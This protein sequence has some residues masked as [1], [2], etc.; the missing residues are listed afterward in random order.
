MLDAN[1]S[2][3]TVGMRRLEDHRARDV[4]HREGVLAPRTQM[5]ELNFSGSSVAIGA[6]TSAS[7]G[8]S[9]PNVR[10]DVLDRVHEEDRAED[11][12]PERHEDLEVHDPQAR[13]VRLRAVRVPVEPMEAERRECLAARPRHRPRSGPC[14]YQA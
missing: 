6:M 8:S 1:T 10:R 9:T 11:D 4:A 3:T 14:T 5:I 7:S 13:H 12:E 2:A